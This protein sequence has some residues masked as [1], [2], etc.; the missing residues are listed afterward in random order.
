M[1]DSLTAVGE[2]PAD[3]DLIAIT[4]LHMDHIGWL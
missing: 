2:T 3:I 4:H 1:L